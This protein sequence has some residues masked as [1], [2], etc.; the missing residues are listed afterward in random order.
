MWKSVIIFLAVYAG[1]ILSR[2]YRPAI[3]WAG[4]IVALIVGSIGFKEVLTSISWNV[5]GIFLGSLI[6][7]ELFIISKVPETIADILINKSPNLGVAF[8]Y[9][10]AFT[11]FLS[12]FIENVATVLIVA[13]VALQ[14]AKKANVNPTTV[15]IGLA[16]S[17]NLQ[18]SA[19]LIGDP[20][21]MILAAR[22]K[23]NFLDFFWYT[24]S[25]AIRLITQND[26]IRFPVGIFWLVQAGAI[27]SFAV[28][29]YFLKKYRQKPDRIPVSPVKTLF[30]SLLLVIMIVLLS[31]ASFVDP[32]F[33]WFGGAVCM[34]VGIGGLA[35]YASFERR[36]IAAFVKRLDYGTAAFLAA[37]F[38]LVAMLEY[39][40]AIDALVGRFDA[41]S[42][43]NSFAVYSIVVWGS[44]FVSAFI[45][46][47]PYVTAVLPVVMG[48]GVKT[49]MPVELF[50]FGAL[51]GSCI[52]GNITPIGA[53]A[54]IV[55][56]SMLRKEGRAVSFGTF[57][58]IGLPFTFTATV[59][60][61]LLLWWIYR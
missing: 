27:A 41:F 4:I 39:N 23:M 46:N 15:I 34:L 10:I 13:P 61:Y 7:A 29:W 59:V 5:I 57:V 11:S 28:L 9:I 26:S 58:K 47:V 40:G 52:G 31:L 56:I 14:L 30:P 42:G 17:S 12:A 36:E 44:V 50:A 20:P 48:L 24:R 2:R 16:I 53:S 32:D 22:L 55:A 21:S 6:L 43:I 60:S 19:T 45:D 35:W 49:G 51:I 3:A 54:N 18:G 38:V 33:M 1:L 8:L 25:D 37:V